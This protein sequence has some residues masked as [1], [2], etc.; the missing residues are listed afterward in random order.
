MTAPIFIHLTPDEDAQR[1]KHTP[2]SPPTRPPTLRPTPE[3]T[4][5]RTAPLIVRRRFV[6]VVRVGW[7][8]G[9]VCVKL[10]GYGVASCEG[11][12]M[13]G[14]YDVDVDSLRAAV[15]AGLKQLG[16]EELK[17]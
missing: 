13:P 1:P 15:V 3:R 7:R 12:V 17:I 10:D 11:G 4:P 6:G 8:V 14:R 2:K 5:H 16:G 9:C